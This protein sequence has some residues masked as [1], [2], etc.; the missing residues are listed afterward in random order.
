MSYMEQALK[1]ARLGRGLTSPNPMVGCVIVKAD[2]VIGQGW[3]KGSGQPHAEVEALAQAGSDA[4][5]ADMYINLEP[6]CHYGKTPPCINAV[7]RAKIKRVYIASKDPN[8]LVKGNG[9]RALKH[10]GIQVIL[11]KA[12]QKKAD[13]LNEDFF[14]FIQHKTPFVTAKWAMTLDGKIATCDGDSKWIT[15]EDARRHVHSVRKNMDAILV[16]ANTVTMDNPLLTVRMNRHTARQPLRI[17]L[18]GSGITPPGA[19]I[20]QTTDELNTLVFTTL[21]SDLKWR[22][23][24]TKQGVRISVIDGQSIIPLKKLLQYL[25]T[26]NIMNL[27][28]EGGTSV[29]TQFFEQQCVNK[30]Y[31][32]IAPKIVGGSASPVKNLNIREMGAAI[33]LKINHTQQFN[34]DYL[35]AGDVY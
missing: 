21:A 30:F 14:H 11:L 27:L 20:Y 33:S 1:L 9:I 35:I 3:H 28:V 12:W 6:C 4:Q 2:K 17:V 24:L 13:T 16:G 34:C 22:T 15:S 32:Y 8:P 23:Q 18:D 25:G 31:T 29:L 26:L 19:N 5:D 10:A 7:I